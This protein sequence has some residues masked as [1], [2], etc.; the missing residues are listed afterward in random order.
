MRKYFVSASSGL[1]AAF[2]LLG[3]YFITMRI[4]TGSWTV[5]WSQ[6]KQLWYYMIPLTTGF[7]I[8]VGLFTYLKKY[9]DYKKNRLIAANST[10]STLAMIA[11]CTHHLTD[12]LPFLGLTVL[13]SLLIQ[14]Q[15][16]IL[17]LGIISNGVGIILLVR[18][19]PKHALPVS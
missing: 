16:P 10:T 12:I 5:A 17:F 6:F 8:Q 7:G 9:F 3:F 19:I 2:G 18:R 13:S 1:A 11:C 14:F 15:K 4:F